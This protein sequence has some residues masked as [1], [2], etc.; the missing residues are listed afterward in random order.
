MS[1][2]KKTLFI[3]K[4]ERKKIG[5]YLLCNEI[6]LQFFYVSYDIKVYKKYKLYHVYGHAN[7]HMQ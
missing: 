6:S 1:W 3:H 7:Y 2:Q 4:C 5:F